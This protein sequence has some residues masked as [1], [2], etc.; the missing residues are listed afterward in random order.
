MIKFSKDIKDIDGFIDRKKFYENGTHIRVLKMNPYATNTELIEYFKLQDKCD[1]TSDSLKKFGVPY[2]LER[3]HRRWQLTEYIVKDKVIIC[4]SYSRQLIYHI[5]S[6][7]GKSNL[8]ISYKDI[9]PI[10]EYN[11]ILTID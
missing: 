10:Q 7:D 11:S 5:E 9:E 8:I 1:E 3:I 6:I 2:R 4:E